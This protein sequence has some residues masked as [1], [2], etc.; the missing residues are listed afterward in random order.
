MLSMKPST[1]IVKFMAPGSGSG[2]R[3]G[4]LLSYSENMFNS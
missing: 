2:P 4:S 3:A 1:T